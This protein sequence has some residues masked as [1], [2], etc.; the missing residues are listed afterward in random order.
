MASAERAYSYQTA[1]SNSN[2]LTVEYSLRG[3]VPGMSIDKNGLV[4]WNS[5]GYTGPNFSYLIIAKDAQGGWAGQI[6]SLGVCPADYP[7]YDTNKHRCTSPIQFTSSSLS[8]AD[9]DQPYHYQVT[10]TNADNLPVNLSLSGA[11]AG[12]SIDGTRLI[13]WTAPSQPDPAGY[14]GFSI[15]AS[16]S[17]GATTTQAFRLMLCQ[18]PPSWDSTMNSCRGPVRITSVQP[19]NGLNVGETF[20]YQVTAIDKDVNGGA[21]K[22]SITESSRPTVTIDPNSGLIT[23]LAEDLSAFDGYVYFT[24][25]ATDQL[26]QQEQQV[27]YV[28]TCA[29]PYRWSSVDGYCSS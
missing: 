12:M 10:T 27:V 5:S 28:Y 6:V 29:L 9:A 23:W 26:G 14:F 18:L 21:I 13:S 16:D 4:S 22:Y 8:G 15:T 25:T 7:L 20:S 2:G 17:T 11:P 1:V 24:I 19:V 3:A